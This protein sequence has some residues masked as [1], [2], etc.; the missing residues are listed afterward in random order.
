[1]TANAP[2]APMPVPDGD[3]PRALLARMGRGVNVTR[4]FCYQPNY[5][6]PAR[7]GGYLNAQDAANFRRLG[8]TWVRLCLSPDAVFGPKGTLKPEVL[9]YL[10]RAVAWF[11]GR[12]MAVLLDLH[13]NG[14]LKLDAPG[15]SDADFLA[16]WRAMAGRYRGKGYDRTAFE[17]VNEPVFEKNPEAWARMQSRAVTAIRAVD[18]KRTIMVSGTKWSGR[19]TLLAMKP[20]AQR[21]LLY[22]FHCYEPFWFTHQGTIWAGDAPKGMR[23]VPFPATPE[24]IEPAAQGTPKPYDDYLRDLARKRQ[25]AA[26]LRDWIG[27]A[28]AWGRKNRVPVVLGEFGAYPPN[29]PPDSRERWFAAMRGAIRASGLPNSIWGYDDGFGLGRSVEGGKVKVDEMVARVFYGAK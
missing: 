19:D 26:F 18:P 22:T 29:S 25:G 11:H 1:M 24:N 5:T 10:D 20:L 2:A 9:P 12:N 21:N 4:W 14:Q 6:D 8:V 15:R 27:S 13:D 16:F 3:V 7:M 17:L 28:A 23:G